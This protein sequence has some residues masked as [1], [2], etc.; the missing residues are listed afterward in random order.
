MGDT[1]EAQINQAHAIASEAVKVAKDL[2]EK[3]DATT[4]RLTE[5]ITEL[6]KA[7]ISL[8]VSLDYMQKDIADI[9]TN[10]ANKYITDQ[11]F[12]PVADAVKDHETRMR[13]L[14]FR[15]W[16]AVGGIALG[17]VLL[18]VFSH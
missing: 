8:Q 4:R 15:V 14:E 17:V 13:K 1:Y 18:K 12:K 3:T 10:L 9:K 7:V 16:A 11:T 5:T 2:A 6:S